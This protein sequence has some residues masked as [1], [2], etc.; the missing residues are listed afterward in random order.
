[1]RSATT[2]GA[3]Y[4][5]PRRSLLRFLR[6]ALSDEHFPGAQ[7]TAWSLKSFRAKDRSDEPPS[8]GRN[9]EMVAHSPCKIR[10]VTA[11]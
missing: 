11:F 10:M 7:V 9:D 4:A 8:G 2:I 5:P 6:G 3:L 1:M